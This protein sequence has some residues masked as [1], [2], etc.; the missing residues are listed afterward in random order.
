MVTGGG[1]PKFPVSLALVFDA[2]FH[3]VAVGLH[4]RGAP[5][6]AAFQTVGNHGAKRFFRGFVQ[7]FPGIRVAPND[8]APAPRHQ[9]HQAAKGQL[10]SV[11]IRVNVRVIVFQRSDDQVVGMVMKKFRAFVPVRGIVLISLQNELFAAAAKFSATPPTKKLGFFPAT[12]KSPGKHGRGSRFSVRA[13]H[14]NRMLPGQ[15]LFLQNLRQRMVF[16]LSV[17]HLLDFHVAAR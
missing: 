13:A 16:Q 3:A 6:V 11:E 10:V 1:Q 9:I 7:R 8:D 12:F 14:N 15:K 5:I 4:V 2:E 17:K